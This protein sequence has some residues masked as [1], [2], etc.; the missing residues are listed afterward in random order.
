MIIVPHRFRGQLLLAW[1]ALVSLSCEQV[2]PPGG[3]ELLRPV[4]PPG[5]GD[6]AVQLPHSPRVSLPPAASPSDSTN[7]THT[8]N[9]SAHGKPRPPPLLLPPPPLHLLLCSTSFSSSSSA[10]LP[11]MMSSL[12]GESVTSESSHWLTGLP[13]L[14]PVSGQFVPAGGAEWCHTG[15]NQPLPL[16]TCSSAHCPALL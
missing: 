11:V 10:L 7:T 16:V 3:G 5:G 4:E 1:L 15:E 14:G 2:E 13:V 6:C 12:A 9:V 8:T